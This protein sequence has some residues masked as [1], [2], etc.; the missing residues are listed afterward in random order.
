MS[1][2]SEVAASGF[3]ATAAAAQA[4]DSRRWVNSFVFEAWQLPQKRQ[5]FMPSPVERGRDGGVDVRAVLVSDG[6][7]G[8]P[9]LGEWPRVG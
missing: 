4:Y 8:E 3:S 9:P 1:R 7:K 2:H 6:C 5:A